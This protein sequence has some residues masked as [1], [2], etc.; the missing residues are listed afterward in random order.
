MAVRF[1]YTCGDPLIQ[2]GDA[3]CWPDA[4][5]VRVND[6]FM[7]L[8]GDMLPD[9]LYRDDDMRLGIPVREM[10]KYIAEQDD[11]R[12]RYDSFGCYVS[13]ERFRREKN[14]MQD[15]K[16]LN[17]LLKWGLVEIGQRTWFLPEICVC[18]TERG[19]T[20]YKKTKLM[21]DGL[22]VTPKNLWWRCLHVLFS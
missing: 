11:P 13:Q 17:D 1:K 7:Y 16:V 6:G 3:V 12:E 22:E 5:T 8:E 19:F 14:S 4:G 9:H 2:R 18:L 15:E 20:A 10:L 21:D